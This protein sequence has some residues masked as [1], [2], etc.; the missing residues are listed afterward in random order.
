MRSYGWIKSIP[1]QGDERDRGDLTKMEKTA[2]R[3]L[4]CRMGSL[5]PSL[6]LLSKKAC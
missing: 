3:H 5:V 1:G 6:P 2:N 4:C